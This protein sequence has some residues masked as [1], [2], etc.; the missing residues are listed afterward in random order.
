VFIVAIPFPLFDSLSSPQDQKDFSCF[1]SLFV[2]ISAKEEKE[3]PHTRQK[4]KEMNLRLRE[5]N[6]F[7]NMRFWS[8]TPSRGERREEESLRLYNI[9]NYYSSYLLLLL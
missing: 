1:F 4:Q 6:V 2:I 9:L 3:T 5:R 8:Q 7:P